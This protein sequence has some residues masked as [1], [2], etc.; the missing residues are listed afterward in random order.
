MLTVLTVLLPASTSAGPP[1]GGTPETKLGQPASAVQ[2][3]FDPRWSHVTSPSPGPARSIGLPGA[4]CVQG[5]VALS[6]RDP[7]YVLV[8][9][10]RKRDFGHPDLIAYLREV[11][12]AAGKHK[13]GPLYI[14]DLGQ[15]RG[16]PTPTGH[17]SHQ[18]G[19]DVDVW[20]GPPAKPI[21]AGKSATPPS[22]VDLRTNKMSPAWDR[23]AAGLV[24][25]AASVPSVD[26]IFVHPAVKRALCEDKTRRGSWLAR[27]RPWWG[28]QDHFHVRL[29]CPA[30]SPDCT[31]QPPLTGGEG[32][33]A[34]LNWWF[35]TD[36]KTTAS[37]RGPPGEGAPAMPQPCDALL[38][39]RL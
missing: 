30:N 22:V 7:K 4:G 17:R 23:R 13:L 16:G 31:A 5:A 19:L 2:H 25:L 14:G 8:H 12:A 34:S 1:D 29:R 32:C 6:Q 38:G 10:E 20:Y 36:A 26:R 18:N 11:A 35:S 3:G 24:E 21:R 9:P 33:D 28:H 37:K 27:V 39:E 15:A